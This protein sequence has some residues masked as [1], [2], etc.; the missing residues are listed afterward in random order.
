MDSLNTDQHKYTYH[1]YCHYLRDIF[2]FK[3]ERLPRF[4]FH[5]ELYKFNKTKKILIKFF[6][7][8]MVKYVFEIQPCYSFNL[9]KTETLKFERSKRK[10]FEYDPILAIVTTRLFPLAK[11]SLAEMAE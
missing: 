10:I 6:G 11:F 4:E 9:I 1:L 5:L 3:F 7:R 8:I 2:V